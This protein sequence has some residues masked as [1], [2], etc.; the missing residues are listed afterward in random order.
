MEFENIFTN[1]LKLETVNGIKIPQDV[2]FANE[3][4]TIQ[5]IFI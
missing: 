2:V 4:T 1:E 3:N 5:G